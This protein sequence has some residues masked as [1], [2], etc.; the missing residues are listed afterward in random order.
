MKPTI[1]EPV[2]Q[3]SGISLRYQYELPPSSGIATFI[4]PFLE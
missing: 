4:S 1:D 3:D 2:Q